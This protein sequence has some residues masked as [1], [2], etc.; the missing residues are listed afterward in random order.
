[1]H[2][3]PS[4]SLSSI[5][6]QLALV[7]ALV[8]ANAFFVAAEFALVSVRR[9]RID[10]L[11]AEGSGAAVVVQR[12][13]RDL[14]RYIAAT[15]VG[16]TIA[17][18]LLGGIGERVLHHLLGPLFTWLPEG[19]RGLTRG[20]IATA[21]AYFIMTAMHVIIGELMPK[22]IALQKPEM[23][24]LWVGR[25][26][27][28]IAKL[29]TPLIWMLNG[30]GNFLLR[31]LGLHATEGHA[32]VHSPEEL[33]MIIKQSHEG[34][35][36]NATEFEILHRVVKFSDLTAREVMV[37]R[38]EMQALPVGITMAELTAL[39]QDQP[40]TRIPVYRG[41][42][43]DIIGI[44]HL[45]DMV[46]LVALADGDSGVPAGQGSARQGSAG[47]GSTAHATHHADLTAWV[48]EAARVPETMTI[49]RLLL[50]FKK[51]RQQMAIVIDE[52]GG[53]AGLVTMGD[54]LEQVF[55][56][57]H[58]E[59]D[60]PEAEIVEQPD[61]RVHLNG[62]VL[63]D[64][65][66]ERYNLNFRTDEV[67]TMAGLILGTLGRPAVVGDEVEI[68]GARLRVESIDRLRITGLSLQRLM[69]DTQRPREIPPQH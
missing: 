49:D 47:Q 11:A 62:R 16:I 6:W 69:T 63:I 46:R 28:L 50:E 61:G 34:G 37:P 24:S 55:G 68:D 53:T 7:F 23:T 45:K 40:H 29:F 33:D 67:D 22:S 8:L 59:F 58:D 43:D 44:A 3:D 15:Q 42:L 2:P 38:V 27:T 14:D 20:G 12:A 39:L 19:T 4:L 56:D 52:Y 35:E 1:M 10:Q 13:L 18:L 64:V 30:T 41:S 26:M 66:N 36:L 31:L 57:V 32:Q 65:V 54:L 5:A 25:P 48:R 21:F 17:S 60:Q 51:R 9:T